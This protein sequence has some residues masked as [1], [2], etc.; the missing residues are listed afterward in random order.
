MNELRIFKSPEFGQ[1]RTIEIGG[2][3]WF[4]G[5]DV[6]EA[7]G[8]TNARDALAKHVDDTDK[9]QEDGVAIR[10]SIGRVQYPTVINE[11]GVFALIFNSKLPDA[12]RFKHWVTHEVL[13]AIRKHGMYATEDLLNDPDLAIRA[14]TALKE[15]RERN[16]RLIADNERMRPKEIFADAV[17]SSNTSILVGDLAKILKQNG[18][19]IGQKRLFEWMRNNGYLIK[20]NGSDWNM[21][22][23]RA[24][25]AG[26]FE[27]KESTRLDANG[28]NITI[29][30][31]KVTGKGQ[32]YFVNKFLQAQEAMF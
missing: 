28:C 8:Y 25:E 23:Q 5:K 19:N 31:T 4:V 22:M 1:I 15:E 3:L 29:R 17:A 16:K 24:M 18:I 2:E 27:I 12:K 13:P 20:R 32:V 26:L 9:K 6:A 10:D 11:S 30:T 21:P 14:F 7:L